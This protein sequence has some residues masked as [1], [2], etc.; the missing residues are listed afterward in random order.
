MPAAL[1]HCPAG[2]ICACHLQCTCRVSASK[3]AACAI[4][5]EASVLYDM[6]HMRLVSQ[7][8]NTPFCGTPD[9]YAGRCRPGHGPCGWP[10]A[11][12]SSVQ[13][14]GSML[15]HCYQTCC[16]GDK[17]LLQASQGCASRTSLRGAALQARHQC[18]PCQCQPGIGGLR[19]A[20]RPSR[21]TIP[22]VQVLAGTCRYVWL[23]QSR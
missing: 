16:G 22:H 17:E 3:E 6:P 7:G 15:P 19:A 23:E 5:R 18:Q 4:E 14:V 1:G 11:Q 8:V 13:A 20:V 21:D 9:V 2:D 10:A 12:H